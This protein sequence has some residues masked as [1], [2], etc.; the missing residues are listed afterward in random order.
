MREL[1]DLSVRLGFTPDNL[2][3]GWKSD[4]YLWVCEMQR[5]LRI[6]QEIDITIMIRASSSYEF[7][8]HKDRVV[9]PN[10]PVTVNAQYKKEMY[11]EALK[12]AVLKAF[13]LVEYEPKNTH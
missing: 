12:L 1:Y 13:Q 5:L 10:M 11:F 3:I 2:A 4:P 9:L 7:Y 6:H 8:I